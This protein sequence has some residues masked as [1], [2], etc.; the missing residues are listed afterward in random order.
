MRLVV[1]TFI[2]IEAVS[3]LGRLTVEEGLDLGGSGL[4]GNSRLVWVY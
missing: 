4:R 3:M 2:L 1:R